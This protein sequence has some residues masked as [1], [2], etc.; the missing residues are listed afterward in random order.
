[1]NENAGSV[2]NGNQQ[3]QF[4]ESVVE[5]DALACVEVLGYRGNVYL[6]LGL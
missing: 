5:D 1:M 4:T 2:L 3:P 6:S